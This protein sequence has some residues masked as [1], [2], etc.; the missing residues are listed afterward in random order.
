[1]RLA[2]LSNV[3]TS[4]LE[5]MLRKRHV[6]W[7]PTGFGAWMETALAP[8]DAMRAF[9]P[10]IVL[11]LLD[12]H[13]AA[14]EESQAEQ[15][16]T[17]LENAFP[18]ASVL[19]IDLEDLADETGDFYDARMWKLGAMPWSMRGLRAL[20]A[21]ID[22]LAALSVGGR[23]KVLALDLDNTLWR[24]VIGE[25]GVAGV[26]PFVEFQRGVKALKARGVLLTVL[27]KNNLAD[28]KP[29]WA[30]PRMVLQEDDFVDLRIDWRDKAEN[31]SAAA[32]KLNLG[33]DAFVFVDDNPAERAQMQAMRPE[34]TVPDFP[35]SARRLARLYFPRFRVTAEDLAKTAQY[36]AEARRS[37]FAAGLTV[38][39]YLKGLE[40]WADV[41]PVR[42]EEIARVAQLSQKTN[43][44]NVLT[45]RYTT[46][47]ITAFKADADRILLTVQ[48]GDRFG[49]QGLVAFV[50]AVRMEEGVYSICD[51]V[52]SC[53]T[54]NRRLEFAVQDRLEEA[55][56]RRG[57]RRLLA[58]W[59]RTAKNAPVADLFTAFGFTCTAEGEDA[60]EYAR[61]LA[62]SVERSYSVSFR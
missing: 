36:Q 49:D 58:T 13:F 29:V 12:R 37:A 16:V 56:R 46:D 1:V 26:E 45:N 17:L 4:V 33:T 61:D 22:R 31:L 5:G 14:Y 24:G 21:E 53:R 11:L 28:V 52:M 18:K 2:V 6:L 23:K 32:R 3:T 7:S 51:W 43:Q 30:D 20:Q 34:V 15:A 19:R 50:Q 38:E 8:S 25:D 35:I 40:I 9:D 54:M 55:V 27:S 57:G 59:R 60:R 42:D 10:E 62:V 44:F 39:A 41:H 47:D 48:A